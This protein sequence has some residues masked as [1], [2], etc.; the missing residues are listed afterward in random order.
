MQD[1][2]TTVLLCLRWAAASCSTPELLSSCVPDGLQRCSGRIKVPAQLSSV[3]Q[4]HCRGTCRHTSKGSPEVLRTLLLRA[5]CVVIVL[6]THAL[7]EALKVTFAG[8]CCSRPLC[9]W[10]NDLPHQLRKVQNDRGSS[11]SPY[12]DGLFCAYPVHDANP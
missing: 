10:H 3:A 11:R 6:H 8:Q 9:V 5:L 1:P 7:I 12:V 2:S 4:L